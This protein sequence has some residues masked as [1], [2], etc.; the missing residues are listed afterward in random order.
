MQ[1]MFEL[2]I[3]DNVDFLAGVGSNLARVYISKQGENWYFNVHLAPGRKAEDVVPVLK[4]LGA[5]LMQNDWVVIDADP[6]TNA[7]N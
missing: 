1:F 2:N 6:P 4:D 5:A 3:A 7:R